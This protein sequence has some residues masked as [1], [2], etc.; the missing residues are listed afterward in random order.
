MKS[1]FVFSP[2]PCASL[3][4]AAT[5]V[6][7]AA[8]LWTGAACGESVL[9][10]LDGEPVVRVLTPTAS[11]GSMVDVRL[12]NPTHTDWGY[13][14]CSTARLELLLNNRWTAMPQP[15]QLCAE[16]LNSL[17]PRESVQS[18]VYVPLG[19]QPGVYRV[20][21]TFWRAIGEPVSVPSGSFTVE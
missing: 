4:R 1:S 19:Y 16:V 6:A 2:V 17:D 8:T 13:N 5:F 11:T 14:L 12:E 10:P 3:R 20:K 7:V 15:L 21:V 18:A 9:S